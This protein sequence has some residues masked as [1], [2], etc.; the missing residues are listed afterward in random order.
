VPEEQHLALGPGES[1]AEDHIRP[2]INDRREHFGIL[3]RIVFQIGVLPDGE[4]AGHFVNR[5]PDRRT[6][7]HVLGLGENTNVLRMLGREL[8]HHTPRVVFAAI[9]HDDQ[10]PLQSSGDR[11]REDGGDAEVQAFLLIVR[12]HEDGEFLKSGCGHWGADCCPSLE[13]W[14]DWERD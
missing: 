11:C 7:A 1:A 13:F 14:Q 4:I 9:V 10:F 12:S 8:L 3:L 5:P 2:A 6:L